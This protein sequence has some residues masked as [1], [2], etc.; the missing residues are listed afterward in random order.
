M[1]TQNVT[2][3][4][5]AETHYLPENI[6]VAVH[7]HAF[8]IDLIPEFAEALCNIPVEFDLFVSIPQPN[9]QKEEISKTLHRIPNLKNITI[10]Q[11]PNKGRDIAPMLCTFGERLRK[12]DI[13]LH[14]HTKKS[15]HLKT[16]D[17]WR[18]H[19]LEHL[20]N[21]PSLVSGIL[22]TLNDNA[23]IVTCPSFIPN[24]TK[25]GWCHPQNI[26]I[27][28]EILNRS[29]L[30]INLKKEFPSI[31]Y[32]QGSMFWARTD[33]MEPLFDMHLSY[34]DFDKEPLPTDGTFAH[35][36]ERL[37]FLWGKDTNMHPVKVY[38]TKGEMSFIKELESTYLKS[39]RR[40]KR[41]QILCYVCG[42]LFI[43]LL[44]CLIYIILDN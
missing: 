7:L 15:P 25:D 12:Y 4:Q 32:P 11:T 14:L 20:L 8:Y 24:R 27:S 18:Q 36:L 1:V 6:K 17:G 5:L 26:E 2:F 33:Y 21:S 28:Q 41:C 16:S 39:V 43:S 44:C 10:E 40:L 22:A 42:I 19:I 38:A 30:N 23:G 37:F 13:F 29:N 9:F 3:S 34:D 35:A 31:D